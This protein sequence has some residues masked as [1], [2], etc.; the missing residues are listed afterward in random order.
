MVF[1]W[2]CDV[3]KLLC[4]HKVSMYVFSQLKHTQYLHALCVVFFSDAFLPSRSVNKKENLVQAQS[5]F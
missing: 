3:N 2:G 1:E 4:I 5:A